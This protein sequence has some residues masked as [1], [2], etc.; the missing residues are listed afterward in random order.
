MVEKIK[1]I[2][3]FD[4]IFID[5]PPT[6]NSD[7]TNNAVYASDYILMV[8]QTQQSAYESSLSFVNFKGIEKES[9]L[10]FEL[11]GAVPVLI[12]KVDV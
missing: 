7:F 3:D 4:Y 1:E 5:V 10:S 6:I 12:K 2:H 11:V 8:F 9:D